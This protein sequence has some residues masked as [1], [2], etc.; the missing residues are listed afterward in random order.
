MEQRSGYFAGHVAHLAAAV[1]KRLEPEAK[2]GGEAFVMA[3]WAEQSAAAAAVQQM[4]LRFAGGTDA[5]ATLARERQDLSA[6]RR[7]REKLLLEAL[8]KPQGEQ[9]PAAFARLRKDLAGPRASSPP[10]RPGSSGS[11]RLCRARQPQAAQCRGCASVARPRGSHRR[12]PHRR[13]GQFRVRSEPRALRVEQIGIGGD[14]LAEKVTAFREGLDLE[15]LQN[16]AGKAAPF[17]LALAHELYVTLLGP[18]EALVKDKRHL[19]VVPAG[20]LTSLPFHLL[21]TEK[22][23]GSAPD[24]DNLAAYRDAA[25][26]IKRQ[27]MPCCLRSPVSRPCAPSQRKGRAALR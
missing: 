7:S 12:L 25:W 4:G 26:L 5:L 8:G 3:Q 20:A 16:S 24:L 18:V 13:R 14:K 22:P 11:P 1:Q 21:V 9:N 23:T 17:D 6:F 2:L 19:M 10:T 15:K 27:A